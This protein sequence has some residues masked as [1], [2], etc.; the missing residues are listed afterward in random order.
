MLYRFLLIIRKNIRFNVNL[1]KTPNSKKLK[2]NKPNQI[3]EETNEMNNS[4]IRSIPKAIMVWLSFAYTHK[5]ISSKNDFIR[6]NPLKTRLKILSKKYFSRKLK[7]V[8]ACPN[9]CITM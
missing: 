5:K 4:E 7:S 6:N 2:A 1:A 3:N 8:T 9:A